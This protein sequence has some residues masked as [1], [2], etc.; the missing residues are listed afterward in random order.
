MTSLYQVTLRGKVVETVTPKKK[1][2]KRWF[3]I[4]IRKA[5][6]AE[7]DREDAIVGMPEDRV[8][9]D[10]FGKDIVLD[11]SSRDKEFDALM[12]PLSMVFDWNIWQMQFVGHAN[13]KGTFAEHWPIISRFHAEVIENFAKY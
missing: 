5:L 9:R 7:S 3:Y 10:N 13:A 8:L 2:V 12:Y 11:L 4:D 6:D 1:R